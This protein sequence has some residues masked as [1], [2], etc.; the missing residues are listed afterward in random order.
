MGKFQDPAVPPVVAIDLAKTQVIDNSTTPPKVAYLSSIIKG[1]TT[2]KKLAI[3]RFALV[4]DDT[5]PDG[6]PLSDVLKNATDYLAIR[7][8]ASIWDQDDGEHEFDFKYDESTEK[9]G[10]GTAFLQD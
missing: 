1:V 6:Q 4:A 3:S 5:K 7:T 10:A 8:D 9:F 2:D